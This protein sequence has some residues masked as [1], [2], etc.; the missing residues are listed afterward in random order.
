MLSCREA[1]P[2]ISRHLDGELPIDFEEPLMEHLKNCE[3]CNKIFQRDKITTQK[4]VNSLRAPEESISKLGRIMETQSREH[5]LNE[6]TGKKIPSSSW[7]SH[8]LLSHPRNRVIFQIVSVAA[9][10]LVGFGLWMISPFYETEESFPSL[11]VEKFL[12]KSQSD[13]NEGVILVERN[14]RESEMVPGFDGPPLRLETRRNKTVLTDV[15]EGGN[16]QDSPSDLI[17]ELERVEKRLIR[18]VS[19]RWR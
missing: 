2:M 15:P 14:S 18:P 6:R 1:E 11:T 16:E 10:V 13:H 12:E 19:N 8:P 17:L 3:L 7:Q 4:L 9:S 5:Y